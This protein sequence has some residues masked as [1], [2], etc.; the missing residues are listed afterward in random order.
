MARRFLARPWADDRGSAGPEMAMV[1]PIL[2]TLILGS[3]ELGRYFLHEHTVVKA[4]RD[5]ARYASRRKFTDYD[6]ASANAGAEQA[7]RDI[8]R[9]GSIGGTQPRL[10]YW[11]SQST[12]TVSVACDTTGTYKGI[13]NGLAMGAPV[14]TVK[15]SVPYTS[16]FGLLGFNTT[17]FKLNAK[18]ES[19]VMGI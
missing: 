16:L 5:G 1:L 10:V 15:A 11:T 12:I 14:V 9:T 3:F 4:V 8:T 19:A 2:I 6:C 7:I 13:Y 17:G 18:S